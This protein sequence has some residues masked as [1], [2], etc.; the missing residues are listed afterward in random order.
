MG[1]RMGVLI[2]ALASTGCHKI[3]F[4]DLYAPGPI[5]NQRLNA[6]GISTPVEDTDDFSYLINERQ[7][8]RM[9]DPYAAPEVGPNIDDTRPR[10]FNRPSSEPKRIQANPIARIKRY[11]RT[12][13]PIQLPTSPAP[14]LPPGWRYGSPVP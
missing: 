14:T 12:R 7:P 9:V 11:N 4:P 10:D 5:E 3:Q 1:L 8:R 6:A 2:L 13:T